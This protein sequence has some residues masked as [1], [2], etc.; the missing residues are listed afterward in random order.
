MAQGAVFGAL[1]LMLCGG[2]FMAGLRMDESSTSSTRDSRSQLP[3]MMPMKRSL[4]ALQYENAQLRL[5]I[6]KTFTENM[7]LRN[8]LSAALPS[9]QKLDVQVLPSLKRILTVSATG[10]ATAGATAAAA[11]A[12][13]TSGPGSVAASDAGMRPRALAERLRQST[14]FNQERAKAVAT[15]N[16]IILTFVNRVRLD[17]ATTWVMHVKRLG[18]TNWLIGATDRA[19]LR[20]L[21]RSSYPC[22]DMSTNLP[23]GEWPWGSPSF[24][25][26]GPHKI[27]LI[28]KSLLWDLEVVITDIDALVLR[29][30]FAFFK[31]WP[32]AGFLTTSDHLGN[33]TSDGMLEDHRGIHTAFNIGYMFF[34]KSAMPLVEEWRR[35]IKEDPRNRWDQGEFNRLARYKWRPNRRDGLSDPRLFWAFEEKV[36]GGVLPLSLFCGG[37]NYFVSQFAQRQQPPWEPYSIHTTYQ[38]AAAAGKRHRLREAKVWYDP[39]EYYNPP[40]GL[41]SFTLNTPHEMVYPPGGM[42]VRGH[43][44]LINFQLRQLRSALALATALGRKLILPSVTCGYDKY[45]GPLWRGV[46]PGTHTWALPIRDC[47]LDHFIEVGMLQPV[48]NVR[49]YSLLHNVRTPDSVKGSIRH[50]ALDLGAPSGRE[51]ERLKAMG[52]ARVINITT[53]FGADTK[54]DLTNR[55]STL[56]SSVDKR[57]YE[58]KFGFVGGS[59]CCAPMDE[60]KKGAPRSAHFRLSTA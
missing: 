33:T 18:L 55:D 37:H 34:R 35:V 7:M 15:N 9:G 57:N 22:F 49:E 12:A 3:D 45:W 41:L 42:S 20:E 58:R 17:F 11:A 56:L 8:K 28:Y 21:K 54:S 47:P 16:Q 2:L 53:I 43:I 46:I 36:I 30:P 38:Y 44:A 39:P 32:D 23:E 51:V 60:M 24:K 48:E 29:E 50:V 31:P 40:Q 4:A 10:S 13:A 1:V 14:E 26:L 19:S 5:Q 27:E 52:D 59:W 25:S 6:N